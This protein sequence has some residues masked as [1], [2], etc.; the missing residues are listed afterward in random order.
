MVLER[1]GTGITVSSL[2]NQRE[3]DQAQV[4]E[5]ASELWA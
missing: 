2:G 5:L 3:L 1:Q 4:Q